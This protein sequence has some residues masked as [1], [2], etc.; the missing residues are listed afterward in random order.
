[1]DLRSGLLPVAL[2]AGISVGVWGWWQRTQLLIEQKS[3]ELLS[4]QLDTAQGDARRNL[5]TATKLQS[6]LERE[7]EAQTQLLIL[8]SALRSGLAARE[9]QIED[10]K[11]ENEELR[12]WAAQPLPNAA[13]RLRERPA[14]TGADA[15]RQWL[16][17]GGAVSAAGNG[18]ND[19]RTAA[20]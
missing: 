14:I 18:A 13:R 15:Y 2:A 11:H 12:D 7:R 19:Q 16:S 1:M 4:Q 20:D 10:L 9:R 8:Q 17:R 5:D 6:T 3:T